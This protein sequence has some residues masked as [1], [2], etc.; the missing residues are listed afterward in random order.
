MSYQLHYKCPTQLDSVV[1]GN[2]WYHTPR[3][4]HISWV[5]A[6]KVHQQVMSLPRLVH[7]QADCEPVVLLYTDNMPITELTTFITL[8]HL[9]KHITTMTSFVLQ[10]SHHIW[11]L[12][13]LYNQTSY[14]SAYESRY[15][16]EKGYIKIWKAIILRLKTKY[17]KD[18]D[19][20][21]HDCSVSLCSICC[22]ISVSC[23]LGLLLYS[24]IVLFTKKFH[25][26]KAKLQII[27]LIIL[28][29]TYKF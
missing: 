15:C 14:R 10:L 11:S 27:I 18:V 12:W 8:L 7:L 1:S 2:W 24:T 6:G 28:T 29:V 16:E 9:I 17:Q 4:D 25:P 23:F 26:H 20:Y 21:N 5:S 19:T 22:N 13:S 3:L